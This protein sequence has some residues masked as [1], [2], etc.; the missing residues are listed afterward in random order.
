MRR[1]RRFA[2]DRGWSVVEVFS[3]AAQSGATLERD[4]LQ[5]MLAAARKR[6]GPFQA[7]LVD[8]LSRLSRDL[9]DTWKLVFG[10][11]EGVGVTVVDVT[12]GLGSDTPAARVTFGA[13]ALVNDMV[14]QSAR[15]QTHRGSRDARSQGSTPAAAATDIGRCPRTTPPTPCDRARSWSSTSPRPR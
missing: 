15:T 3:D 12:S 13:L 1:C 5:R 10:D 2:E 6:R 9:G 4:G 7:V 14:R 8:D 11:L